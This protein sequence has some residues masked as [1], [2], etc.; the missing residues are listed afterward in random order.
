MRL[1]YL[2]TRRKSTDNSFTIP[3]SHV[4]SDRRV[5]AAGG[6]GQQ[7]AIE[8]WLAPE[9]TKVMLNEGVTPDHNS[10]QNTT[11]N[12][13][14][15]LMVGPAEALVASKVLPAVSAEGNVA[16]QAGMLFFTYPTLIEWNISG[17]NCSE[18]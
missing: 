16:L 9:P 12:S 10:G 18:M 1:S 6:Q 15:P 13:S 5:L 2:G 17:R 11:P 8:S 14:R 3:E 4:Y 7:R